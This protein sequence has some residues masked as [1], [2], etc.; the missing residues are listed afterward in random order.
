L[1]VI[2]SV[3][4]QG[5]VRYDWGRWR[6]SPSPRRRGDGVSAVG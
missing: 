2:I 5:Y 6:R 1:L 4:D 3:E